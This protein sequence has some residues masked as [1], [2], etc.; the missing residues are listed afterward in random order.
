[1]NTDGFPGLPL[2]LIDNGDAVLAMLADRLESSNAFGGQFNVATLESPSASL[3]IKV[4]GGQLHKANNTRLT[5]AA[6]ASLTMAA[7]YYNF[8]TNYVYVTDAGVVTSNTTGWPTDSNV[9]ALAVVV[10][11]T[12]RIYSIADARQALATFG[13]ST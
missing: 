13:L 5:V 11:Q 2:E 8:V 9:A 1:M 4:S 7:S 3:L 6:V 12:T 10:T